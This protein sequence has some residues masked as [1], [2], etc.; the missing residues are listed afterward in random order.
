ML[1]LSLAEALFAQSRFEEAEPT[2]LKR[3]SS[4][5]LSKCEKLRLH[6][7]LTKLH[8]IKQLK[9]QH[10]TRTGRGKSFPLEG[11]SVLRWESGSSHRR[12]QFHH[13][14]CSAIL[15]LPYLSHVPCRP[16]RHEMLGNCLMRENFSPCYYGVCV[17]SL[18][19]AV[20]AP[21]DNHA[22]GL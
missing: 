4:A 10:R 18:M 21:S 16:Q 7:T 3:L 1:E 5:S 9:E 14:M 11:L 8:H 13:C 17:L 12:G 6:I 22:P 19:V 2:C 20:L 15:F